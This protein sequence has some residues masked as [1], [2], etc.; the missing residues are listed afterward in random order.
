M[1]RS[2]PS[3]SPTTALICA[4][5]IRIDAPVWRAALARPSRARAPIVSPHARK[6]RANGPAAERAV[7]VRGVG[8]LRPRLVRRPHA[9]GPQRPRRAHGDARGDPRGARRGR[10]AP[11]ADLRDARAGRLCGGQR[12][13]LRGLRSSDGRLV[14]LARVDPKS[15]PAVEAERCLEAGA[16]GFKLHPRSDDFP[17]PHPGVEAV[18]AI[19]AEHRMPVMIHAGPRHPEPRRGRR[20]L[21]APLPGRAPDPRARRDQRP[22]RARRRRARSAEPPVRHVVVDGQRPAAA[23]HD[24]PAGADPLRERRALRAALFGGWAVS[25]LARAVGLGPEALASIAGGQIERILAGEDLADVGRPPGT[26]VLGAAPPARRACDRLPR[27]GGDGRLPA[28][29][30]DRRRCS[31]RARHA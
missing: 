24:D 1:R 27:G 7:R 30:P 13:G 4:R 18:V 10:S 19:A 11:R 9:H 15:S 12:R 25:R 29:R 8:G 16:R 22:R 20:R 6:R 17:M 2:L 31:S 28:L 26:G 5:A 14:P 3:R 21:R 23:V